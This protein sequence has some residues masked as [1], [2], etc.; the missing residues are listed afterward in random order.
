MDT[1]A[2]GTQSLACPIS[3]KDQNDLG[4]SKIK[5]ATQAKGPQREVPN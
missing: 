4:C 3:T 5:T 1:K 2:T